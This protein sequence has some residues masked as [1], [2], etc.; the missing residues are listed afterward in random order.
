[1]RKWD[2]LP[3][4]MRTDEVKQYYDILIRHEKELRLKRYFDI[5][6]SMILLVI[7]SPIMLV[8][9]IAIKLDSPGPVI[10]KQVR[11]TQYGKKFHILKFRTM[12][13]NAKTSDA[14]TRAHYKDLDEQIRI[15]LTGL[16]PQK[17]SSSSSDAM[18]KMGIDEDESLINPNK[19]SPC[20][21]FM[22]E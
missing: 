20:R 15:V 18:S 12:V 6:L 13:Q 3:K 19:Y 9:S 10:Y 17:S 5:L 21:M 8:I 4:F 22:E 11:V 7:L 16:A 2:E 1:M 14:D